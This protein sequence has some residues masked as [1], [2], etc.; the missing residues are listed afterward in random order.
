MGKDH[1]SIVVIGHVDAGKSTTTGHLIYKCGGISKRKLEA[2]QREATQLGKASFGY[3]FVMDKLKEER[4]SGITIDISLWKFETAN[5]VVTI[6]D[7]PGHRDFVKNM[8]TGTAQADAA[9][10]IIDA[11][12][13]GFESGI[14]ELGQTREHI[15]LAYTLGIKQFIVAVNKMDHNTVEYSEARF[16]EI[17]GEMTRY[18]GSIGIKPEQITFVP[19][20]GFAGDNM[21]EASPN[22]KW[23]KGK[24]LIDTID[25][26]VAPK[27]PLDKPLRLPI[28]DVYKI[29]GIGTVP[30]GRVESGILKPGMNVIFAPA[31]VTSE[32]RSIEMHH[33]SIPE[34]IPGDNI[35]F[36]V[37]GVAA[38]DIKAGFVVGDAKNC[39]PSQCDSFTAQVVVS[40]H[41]GRIHDGYQP[42]FDCHTSH[43][44]CRFD[45]ILKR[46]DRR[47]GNAQIDDPEYLEKGDLGIVRI[48]PT[49]P[50]VVEP[51]SEFPPLGRFAVRDMKQTVAVGIIRSVERKSAK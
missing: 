31:D 21:T 8:I 10:V 32:V 17:R 36:N 23:W 28:Q 37:R 46:I 47:H 25:G 12:R 48:V 14:A 27:R 39:P 30:A 38:S 20:S 1:I 2:L 40:N 18:M 29:G 26:L 16:D 43:I 7:A 51:F 9:V 41:P 6:I 5:H 44:A 24:T 50:M 22:L 49:K 15:L 19:I 3:A 34:A 35:G 42:I 11:T 4:K 33:Q 13:G 45:H